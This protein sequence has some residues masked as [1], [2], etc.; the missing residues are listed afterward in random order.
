MN[1]S[2]RAF[3]ASTTAAAVV[4]PHVFAEEEKKHPKPLRFGV[5]GVGS[6]GTSLLRQLLRLEG[7]EIP[8]ICDI[9]E[10]HYGR[11]ARVVEKERGN[12]PEGFCK[13][14]YDYR[15]MLARDDFDAVLIATPM[16]WHAEMAVDSMNAGKHVA[17]E[18]PGADR[19]EDCWA[20]VDT[21]EKT[22]KKYML[23]ENVHY[24]DLYLAI[25]NMVHQGI[26]GKCY[27]AECSYIHDCN[28]LKF[29][30]RGEL[31]W[32]GEMTRDFYGNRY[33][34]HSLGPVAKW[35]DVN[36]GDLMVSLTSATS[37]ALAPHA[38][39]VRKFGAESEQAKIAFKGGGHCVTLIKTAQ[40]RLITVY[41]DISSCRPL[42]NFYL[43]QGTEGVFDSRQGIYVDGKSPSHQWEPVTAYLERH[44][45]QLWKAEGD[46][47]AT[48]G[49]GGGDFLQLFEFVRAIHE[50]REPQV[51][52]YDSAAWSSIIPLSKAS[53]DAG[54]SSVEVPD[55]TRGKWKTRAP[56]EA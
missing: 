15:R 48:A 11:A 16:S 37:E 9:N 41:Y 30:S 21:K 55:F 6:R 33:P 24:M 18:V 49:H 19:L 4:A 26:L 28:S 54:A 31:T 43:I 1:P 38:Y 22:G 50:D 51:D 5:I 40:D 17:S 36:R 7:I 42:S 20:L 35:M 14:D 8:V 47:A 10:D 29:N 53:I 56:G 2:R 23:L 3:L 13:G 46:R 34:T 45:H 12:T 52:V 39:A 44:R 25:Y 27:Y 32:R